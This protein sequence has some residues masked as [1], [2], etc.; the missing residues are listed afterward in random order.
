MDSINIVERKRIDMLTQDSV[1]ILTQQYSPDLD[2]YI[3][4]GSRIAYRNSP[5]GRKL[6]TASEPKDC[7]TAVLAIW[8]LSPTLEDPVEVETKDE[9]TAS[10][11]EVAN[12]G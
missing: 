4:D 9:A 11:S 10:E 1:S 7:V 3:G 12:N 2:T 6:L 5:N 8:G